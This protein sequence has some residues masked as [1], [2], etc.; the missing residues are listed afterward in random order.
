MTEFMLNVIRN[1]RNYKSVTCVDENGKNLEYDLCNLRITPVGL[2]QDIALRETALTEEERNNACEVFSAYCM[3][4]AARK[5]GC[6]PAEEIVS[7]AFIQAAAKC[8]EKCAANGTYNGFNQL[9]TNLLNWRRKDLLRKNIV[10]KAKTTDDD[11]EAASQWT[12]KTVSLEVI[13]AEDGKCE[14]RSEVN[15]AV[16]EESLSSMQRAANIELVHET[17]NAC[18]KNSSLSQKQIDM[19]CHKFGIGKNY[20]LLSQ[21]EIAEK[22]GVSNSLVSKTLSEAYDIMREFLDNNPMAA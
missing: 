16:C 21:T 7:F 20:E 3:Y 1:Y 14:S 22:Y 11:G 5:I 6:Q 9:F 19:I 4:L 8:A 12:V 13:D 2:L 10:R 18:R 17:L 15:R